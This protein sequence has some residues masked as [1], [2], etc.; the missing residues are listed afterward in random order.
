[1]DNKLFLREARS[2]R[3]IPATRVIPPSEL[4]MW[5]QQLTEAVIKAA[6]A[7]LPRYCVICT[8][9][10]EYNE[11]VRG[12]PVIKCKECADSNRSAGDTKHCCYCTLPLTLADHKAAGGNEVG[13]RSKSVCRECIPKREAYDLAIAS[14]KGAVDRVVDALFELH[15][16]KSELDVAPPSFRR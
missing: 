3:G 8:A 9:D 4:L 7:L 12:H 14:V 1:V 13:W 16:G 15:G 5:R 11:L 10:V 6:S 2:K